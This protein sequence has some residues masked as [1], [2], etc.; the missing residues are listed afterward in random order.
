MKKIFL[1]LMICIS[2]FT[3]FSCNNNINSNSN[4]GKYVTLDFESNP[5]T[6]YEWEYNFS[7][8]GIIDIINKE[9]KEVETNDTVIGKPVLSSFTL[10]GLGEGSVEV[11]FTYKRPWDGG[12]SAYDVV[13]V[14]NVDKDLNITFVEKKKGTIDTDYSIDNF[15]N[16]IFAN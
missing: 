8:V 7:Q 14:F 15:P 9:T 4:K 6:G 13:Y 11:I 1:T 3:I 5:S 16:P 10:A 12:E 2:I